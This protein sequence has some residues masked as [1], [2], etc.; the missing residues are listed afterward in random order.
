MNGSLS[1]AERMSLRAAEERRRAANATEDRI[2]RQERE[3]CCVAVAAL[4]ENAHGDL[5]HDWDG[6]W[7]AAIEEAVAAIRARDATRV[8]VPDATVEGMAL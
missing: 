1:P 8:H 5:D 6:G 2:R 3:A 7:E 4:A